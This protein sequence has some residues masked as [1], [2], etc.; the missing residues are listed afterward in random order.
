MNITNPMGLIPTD[1]ETSTSL[2]AAF[3]N[4][5]LAERKLAWNQQE[6]LE[7]HLLNGPLATLTNCVEQKD[8]VRV[9]CRHNAV[10]LGTLAAFD[11]HL[12]LFLKDVTE[13]W[14]DTSKKIR[15]EQAYMSADL[16]GWKM[17]RF[18][19]Q[20]FVRGDNII[21]ICIDPTMTGQE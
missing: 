10:L 7:V 2:P 9:Y 11:R 20:M 19:T 3:C 14:K 6:L 21:L 17:E 5:K 8:Q 1:P 12:N 18:I 15:K 16:S 13:C 4:S